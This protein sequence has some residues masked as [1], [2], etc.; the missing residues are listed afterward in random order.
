LL[1]V[2]VVDALGRRN[3]TALF[4]GDFQLEGPAEWRGG[5]AQGDGNFILAK[6]LPVEGGVNRALLRSTTQAGKV[7]VRTS[8]AGLK[9]ATLELQSRPIKVSGG[10][11][12][13]LA[14]D[15]LASCLGRGPTPA[16]PSFKVSRRAAEVSGAT[17][18]SNAEAAGK[19]FD[20]DETTSWVSGGGA[21]QARIAYQLAPRRP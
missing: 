4:L 11:G 18:G 1:E 15:A 19:S 21:G 3:P 7:V 16:S 12:L 10:L 13:Q 8:A 5:I 6:S 20:D 9:A 17:A 14:T 2:E